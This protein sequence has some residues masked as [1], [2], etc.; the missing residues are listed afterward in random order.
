MRKLS[1]RSAEDRMVNLGN[2]REP[3]DVGIISAG[4]DLKIFTLLAPHQV[5]QRRQDGSVNF[6]QSWATYKAGFGSQESEFWLGNENLYQ[7][8]REGPKE[9]RVE[10]EDFNGTQT[11]AHYQGFRILSEADKYQLVLDKFLEGNAGDSLTLHGGRA[12]STYDADNDT[13]TGNCAIIVKGA[14]WYVA[15]YRSNLNGLYASTEAKAYKYGI[16]WATGRGVG[17]PYRRTLMMLR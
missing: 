2:P 4:L 7:L 6:Y 11:F 8:T 13:S 16:D 3:T 9:L 10:L 5:F 12:F 14:W 17:H 15:C 1:Y